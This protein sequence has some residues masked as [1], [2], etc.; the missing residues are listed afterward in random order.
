M[1]SSFL[2]KP[3]NPKTPRVLFDYFEVNL[4]LMFL[5]NTSGLVPH[6]FN[7]SLRTLAYLLILTLAFSW[8][9]TTLLF[10]E[11]RADGRHDAKD[12]EEPHGRWL[13]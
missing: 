7:S 8:R 9:L 1:R 13:L 12:C 4:I 11:E 5:M 6:F 2:P 3:Q 10:E